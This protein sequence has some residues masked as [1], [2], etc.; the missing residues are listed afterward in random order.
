M[1]C[2]LI[3]DTILDVTRQL[4]VAQG[5][6]FKLRSLRVSL[7]LSQQG[8]YTSH[9]KLPFDLGVHPPEELRATLEPFLHMG[10][11]NT[12]QMFT[13]VSRVVWLNPAHSQAPKGLIRHTLTGF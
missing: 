12:I 7:T 8:L 11:N 1:F 5:P 2:K 6:P 3:L 4:P 10:K 13:L 9:L